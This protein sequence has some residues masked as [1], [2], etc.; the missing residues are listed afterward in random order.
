MS[1]IRSIAPRRA[2]AA[3][4]ACLAAA[5]LACAPA[6]GTAAGPTP[7]PTATTQAAASTTPAASPSAAASMAPL[8]DVSQGPNMVAYSGQ[9]KGHLALPPGLAAGSKAPAVVMIHEWWGLNEYIKSEADRLAKEGYVVLAADLFGGKY[10][11]TQDQARSLTG[12][13]DQAAA[14]KNLQDAV[15]FL[16]ARGDVGEVGALGWCFGGGQSLKLLLAQKDLAAGV[17]YYGALE[18]DP[19][20]L[21]GL[22][23]VLGVFGKLDQ[24]PSPAQVAA[25]DQGLT[26][27]GVTHEIYSYDGAGHAFAN[28]TGGERYN[29]TAAADAWTKTLAFLA[30]HLK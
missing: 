27:A 22:P 30:K 26:T 18:P 16:R 3:A 13:L 23:P 9:T 29:A 25:F 2:R 7:A 10:A 12:G 28:P 5:L 17:I 4:I 15:A 21:K 1:T 19:E 24:G 14:T 6:P 11:T 20:K 8:T